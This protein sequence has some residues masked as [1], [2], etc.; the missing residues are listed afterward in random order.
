MTPIP[1]TRDLVLIGGG[2]AHALV[3]RR[4]GMKPL[5]GARLTVINPGP[6]A[7][8]TGMLPGY[9][10]GH[11]RRDDLEIDLVRLARFADARL[12]LGE[13]EGIDRM[14][15]RIQVAGRSD[16]AY[17]VAS[18]DIGITS[19]L[20]DLPGFLDHGIP[21]KPLGIL[22]RRWATYRDST[23]AAEIVVIGGGVAGV[24]LALAM[25]FAMADR[26]R[27]V[28]VTVI[29][30]GTALPGLGSRARKALLF[31]LEFKGITLME[32][33]DVR[34]VEADGV[35]LATGQRL[36]S[37][38]TVGAAGARPY[39]WLAATGLDLTDGYLDTDAQLRTSDPAI[40]AAGDCAHLTHAP[41]PK[42]GVFAVRAAPVL[43]H[44][45]R[46]D[47]AGGARRRFEPQGDYLKLISLGHKAAL[48][49][50][51][52]MIALSQSVWA[53]KDRI[54]RRFMERLSDLPAMAAPAPLPEAAHG[55]RG[56]MA[57]APLCGGCGAK[58]G[59]AA[60]TRAVRALPGTDR[61]DVTVAAGDDA[62]VLRVGGAQQVITT[63][64]LRAFTGDPHLMARIAAVHAMGD[65]WA[66]GARPQ[67]ALAT[68]I[69]PAMVPQM[70][71]RWLAEIMAGAAQAFDAAGAAIVGGHTT[72]GAEL[73]VGF[74]VTGLLDGPAITL[75]G[76]RPG[77]RL[78]LTRP[79]G[80]GTL[81]AADMAGSARGADV[82]AALGEMAQGQGG[83]A[84]ALAA[85]HAMTDV[86]G[87]GMAGH[88]M[89]MCRAS[90][91]AARVWLEDLPFYAG[92]EDL[93]ARGVRSSLYPENRVVAAEMEVPEGARAALL[94]DP[95]TSGGLLAAMAPEDAEAVLARE[96]VRTWEIGEIVEGA[97]F[98]WV[99]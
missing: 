55:V 5:P 82:A 21:A 50:K 9:V 92:A 91:V 20:P 94:F 63:D 89:E 43:A 95:Q 10:A 17:D 12:I 66:M 32:H 49:E 69:L 62:A 77:D 86:T 58:V 8:Y 18:I 98:V 13:A 44:N 38:F 79:L 16:V 3:L 2:H 7:P 37:Q 93:A 90:R 72:L 14:N 15:Q 23:G 85:A 46:A 19:D 33:T 40:Y 81:L 64:H 73:T 30:R 60:L 26:D 70:Q 80:S 52:G 11:Y 54:D 36:P 87:F 25:H 35:T 27:P 83:V 48:G 6:T 97:P 78:L 84:E 34:S 31:Q 4:W 65:V 99:A 47:L 29:N 39:R 42:A 76:A 53:L 41:R 45:L 57:A 59:S 56:A 67:A 88:L 74:T 24:E 75:A 28:Q 22:A 51:W 71:E 68:V 1:L 61:A 96:D